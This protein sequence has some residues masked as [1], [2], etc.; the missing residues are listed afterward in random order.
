MHVSVCACE[1]E[2]DLVPYSI[3]FKHDYVQAPLLSCRTLEPW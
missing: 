2:R 1:R 3:Q